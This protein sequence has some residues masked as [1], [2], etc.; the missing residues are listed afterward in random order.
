MSKPVASLDATSFKILALSYRGY[1]TSSGRA[2]QS[3]IEMDAQAF[4]KWVSE[5]YSK[6]DT[7]LQIILWGHSLGSAVASS[8]LPTYLSCRHIRSVE[9]SANLAPISGLIMEAPTSNIRDML[10]SLY[11]QKWLPYRYLWPFSWNTWCNAT[12]LKELSD[13]RD[14]QSHRLS[15]QSQSPFIPAIL[16]LSAENDEVIPPYVAGQLELRCKELNLQVSRKHVL[17]A[18]HTEALMKADGRDAMVKF[19]MNVVA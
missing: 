6:P 7:D 15:P 1:W 13:W 10:I 9:K 11:P 14:Q 5:T 3:G 17:G 18:M 16:I 12:A 19:V 4:L 2:T 8:A